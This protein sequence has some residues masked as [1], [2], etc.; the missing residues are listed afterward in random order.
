MS[1]LFLAL[2]LRCSWK[3]ST[4]AMPRAP[5]LGRR[6]GAVVDDGVRALCDKYGLLYIADEVCVMAP[7]SARILFPPSP[8]VSRRVAS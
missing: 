2:A 3:D 8:A 7:A 6:R 4:G 5:A 1:C